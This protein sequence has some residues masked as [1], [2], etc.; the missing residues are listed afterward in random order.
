LRRPEQ[1]VSLDM[2]IYG[3]LTRR[4]L[5]VLAQERGDAIEA[6]EHWRAVLAEC[7]SDREARARLER[8]P[9]VVDQRVPT[10]V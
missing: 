1:F 7:P 6:A 2:G 8:F 5:D 9:L 3:H 4:N 10:P